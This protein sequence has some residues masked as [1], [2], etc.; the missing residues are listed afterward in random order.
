MEIP[1][2]ESAK[3]GS[4][5]CSG[6]SAEGLAAGRNV[7]G[8]RWLPLYEPPMLTGGREPCTPLP[9]DAL[10]GKTCQDKERSRLSHSCFGMT[11]DKKL[12][13]R[14]GSKGAAAAICG[15]GSG[16]TRMKVPNCIAK[17]R[18]VAVFLF[19]MTTPSPQKAEEGGK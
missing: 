18:F 11:R 7:R 8:T 17:T 12:E 2:A 9:F 16:V 6:A 19:L 5:N 10:P 15:A 14:R 3:M 1:Q 13:E 4:C